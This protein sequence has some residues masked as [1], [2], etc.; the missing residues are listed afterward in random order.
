MTQDFSKVKRL[1]SPRRCT[2]V[3]FAQDGGLSTC[4]TTVDK[5]CG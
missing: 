2:K 1:R 3:G 4:L 5:P